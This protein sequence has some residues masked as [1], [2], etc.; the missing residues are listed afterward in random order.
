MMRQSQRERRG[1]SLDPYAEA[2][3]CVASRV[4]WAD[5][6]TY[7]AQYRGREWWLWL[8]RDG[9]FLEVMQADRL[10]MCQQIAPR[11]I[12]IPPGVNYILP[13]PTKAPGPGKYARR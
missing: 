11:L 12:V 9:R 13:L 4:E 2:A 10:K 6:E 1:L 8:V 5:D 3:P 7:Y